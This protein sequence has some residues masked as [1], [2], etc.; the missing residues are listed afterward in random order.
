[1]TIWD[2]LHVLWLT[3]LQFS[4]QT[5]REVMR[6]TNAPS[7]SALGPNEEAEHEQPA[8][9][10]HASATYVG[11]FQV[12]FSEAEVQDE[13]VSVAHEHRTYK[14]ASVCINR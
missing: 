9:V 7:T 2:G 8:C 11:D 1:M 5:I 4:S 3:Q 12:P 10:D 14:N 13:H 6:D